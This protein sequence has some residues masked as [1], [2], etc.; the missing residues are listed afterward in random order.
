MTNLAEKQVD[1][2]LS[3]N[4]IT[5]KKPLTLTLLKGTEGVGTTYL[6]KLTY[7]Q[8]A[9][10]FEIESETISPKLKLQR[11]AEKK[12]VNGIFSYLTKRDNTIFPSAC[13]IVSE[14]ELTTLLTTPL[15]VVEGVIPALADRLFID[16]QGRLGGIKLALVENPFLANLYLDVKILI[17]PTKTIRESRDFVCQIFSD[18]HLSLQKPNTSQNIYFDNELSSSRLAKEVL[19]ICTKLNVPFEDSIAVNGKIKHGH[20][21]TLANLTDFII[22]MIGEGNKTKTN[23]LLDDEGKYE[24]YLTLICQF[25]KGLY[26]HLPLE[27]IQT[28][29]DKAVWKKSIDSNVLTCAIGLKS[30][31]YVGRSLIDDLLSNDSGADSLAVEK[32]AA[33]SVMPI[34]DKGDQL[35]LDK[36]IYQTIEGKLKIVKSSEKRL[37]R[38][39]CNRMRVLPCDDLT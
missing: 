21:Y 5:A 4:V 23:K 19:D 7:Q 1:L 35:W 26:E 18:Y 10:Y 31:A 13:L 34:N 8:C 17:V 22:I 37:A 29:K 25:V 30:L 20:L 32:L 39:I 28:L 2:V 6:T 9:D 38:L 33:I 27:H 16:G 12:R 24:L 3:E 11:E 14:M 15:E 36:E